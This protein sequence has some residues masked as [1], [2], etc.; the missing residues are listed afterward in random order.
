MAIT[1][2]LFYYSFYQKNEISN[3]KD[4]GTSISGILNNQNTLEYLDNVR[5]GQIR[6]TLI[7]AD[8]T[9]VFDT[10]AK[11]SSLGNHLS[12]AEVKEA[13]EKGTGESIRFSDTLKKNFYYYAIRLDNGNVCKNNSVFISDNYGICDNIKYC[14]K[15]SY[16][17]NYRS[18]K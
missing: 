16:A 8:G 5:S 18:H 7:Y 13:F 10:D 12:R 3:I 14:C 17:K 11:S 1:V 4:T 6:I 2:S 15:N 9:V